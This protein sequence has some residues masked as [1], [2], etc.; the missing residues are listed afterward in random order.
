MSE[1]CKL[2]YEKLEKLCEKK[3]KTHMRVASYYICANKYLLIPILLLGSASG[4]GSFI[5]STSYFEEHNIFFTLGVGIAA[6]MNTLLQSFSSAFE[7]STKAEAHKNATESYDQLV[8]QIKFE[9][10]NPD[11]KSEV[12][13]STIEKQ[14]LD[15]KQ[16]CKYTIPDWI[17]EQY[18]DTKFVNFKEDT[19]RDLIK[20]FIILKSNLMWN[21][22]K[23]TEKFMDINFEDIRNDLGFD[24]I[25]DPTETCCQEQKKKFCCF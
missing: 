19:E 1:H 15:I 14:I 10:M 13:I 8:T 16:R 11:S 3:K 25:K 18:N 24:T 6:S 4:I 2:N 5:A 22:K 17:E 23:N 7:F 20:K 9:K 12:F 21:D